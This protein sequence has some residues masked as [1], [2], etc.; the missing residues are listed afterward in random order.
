MKQVEERRDGRVMVMHLAF[1]D[2]FGDVR[3]HRGVGTEQAEEGHRQ[4]GRHALGGRPEG[5]HACGSETQRGILPEANRVFIGRQRKADAR[6]VGPPAFQQAD[7][8]KKVER[9]RA[10]GQFVDQRIWR[11]P[12]RVGH[13]KISP[14]CL[15][16]ITVSVNEFKKRLRKI[17]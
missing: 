12:M 13:R 14:R 17:T 6:E 11:M 5:L 8:A 3:R 2:V 16:R 9:E 7:G 10:L 15:V 4:P 1:H